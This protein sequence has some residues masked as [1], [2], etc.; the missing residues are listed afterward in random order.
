MGTTISLNISMICD[1][2]GFSGNW[3]ETSRTNDYKSRMAKNGQ[4]EE[5][6]D[7]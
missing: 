4:S 6:C 5:I 3:L 1:I 2:I 7:K